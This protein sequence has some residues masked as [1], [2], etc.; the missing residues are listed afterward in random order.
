VTQRHVGRPVSALTSLLI[1]SLLTVS[2][3]I[4]MSSPAS[5]QQANTGY[6]AARALENSL[7][8]AIERCEKSVVSIARARRGEQTSRLLDADYVP[9]QYATGVVVDKQGL[10]LTNYH[11]LGH[12]E[13]N[14]FAVWVGR[15]PFAAHIRATDP[16][17]DLAVLEIE[18]DDLMPMP[19]GDASKL[20]KGQLVIALGNPYAIARDGSPS[21]TWG[22]VSNLGRSAPVIANPSA[23][24]SEK[25]TLHHFGT[26][27]QT[28][29]RLNQGTSG[30]ALLN[31]TGEMV[32]M[33]TALAALAGY[34]RAAGY[35]IPIN[36]TTKRTIGILKEGRQ[37]EYGFLGVNPEPLSVLDRRSGRPG[38][39]LRQVVAG[40]PAALDGLRAGD[41]IT[42]INDQEIYDDSGL[43]R[44]I[45]S[46]PAGSV[47]RL[48]VNRQNLLGGTSSKIRELAL[49]KKYISG[50]FP[51]L[52][53]APPASWRG[54]RVDYV[55]A[56]PE[57]PA[58]VPN[59]DAEGCIAVTEVLPGSTAWKAGMRDHQLITH[60]EGRR[61]TSPAEFFAALEDRHDDVT[62]TLAAEGEDDAEQLVVEAER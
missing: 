10:I 52:A 53:K 58:N 60:V 4:A 32:G 37:P 49:S 30:G 13:Q 25:P 55:T 15:R 5:C 40:T 41:V 43:I 26:L 14:D 59:V 29:A 57:F 36:D 33:T 11:V 35:A 61:V 9:A 6:A 51:S 39:R 28:D 34:E 38:V 56:S 45:S 20:K 48:Q 8:T 46:L 42:R 16:W 1:A 54:L 12:P 3:L 19:L 50:S 44:A 47:A 17:T 22:I 18:A 2:L 21:A 24:E 27:I 7:V 62:L 23:A 31:L